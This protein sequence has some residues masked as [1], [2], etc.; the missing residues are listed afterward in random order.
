M[1]RLRAV[2]AIVLLS[3]LAG[4]GKAADA[5]PPGFELAVSPERVNRVIPGRRPLALIEVSGA[6]GGSVELAGSAA[7]EGATV[8]VEPAAI[9]V[10]EVAEAWIE[11]P[12]VTEEVPVTVAV[13]GVRDD[14]EKSVTFDFSAVPGIDDVE[15]TA[16]DVAAVF[17]DELA[18]KV[19]ALPAETSGL[20]GGTP[21][22]GLLVVTHYAWFTD[23][24]EIGLGWHIMIAPDD[25]AEL[26]VRPRGQ[27]TPTQAFR[28]DSWSTALA[29]GDFTITEIP[30]PQ[31]VTR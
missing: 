6:V 8:I 12:E 31:T 28:L 2:L 27:L 20:T 26:Y 30:A 15:A 14:L 5:P 29:G 16:T 19:D 21:V 22:A 3:G 9:G 4:C 25:F 17:L 13:T 24:L 23:E 10:G 1:N 18:T 7:L 11:L